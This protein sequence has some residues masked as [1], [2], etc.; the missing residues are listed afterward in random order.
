MRWNGRLRTAI[1]FGNPYLEFIFVNVT[2]LLLRLRH[3]I[4][5]VRCVALT[6]GCRGVDFKLDHLRAIGRSDS[7]SPSAGAVGSWRATVAVKYDA[8]VQ[9]NGGLYL[10]DIPNGNCNIEHDQLLCWYELSSWQAQ[11]QQ[12]SH[13]YVYSHAVRR[14]VFFIPF[15]SAS[16]REWI[17]GRDVIIPDSFCISARSKT[18][19]TCITNSSFIEDTFRENLPRRFWSL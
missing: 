1:N 8:T 6:K 17:N 15:P 4:F 9:S 2:S 19:S 3:L 5:G 7:R 10:R 12:V 11:V 13:R 18:V 14:Q 16:G